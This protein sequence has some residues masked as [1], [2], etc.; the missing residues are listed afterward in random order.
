[1]NLLK[2]FIIVSVLTVGLI[3]ASAGTAQAQNVEYGAI[4][5]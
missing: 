4:T 1:M 2:N 5:I 3:A